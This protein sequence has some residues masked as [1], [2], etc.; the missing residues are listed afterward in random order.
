[1]AGASLPRG[2]ACE[3][4]HEF[5][6]FDEVCSRGTCCTDTQ[7]QIQTYAKPL[8]SKACYLC[9]AMQ[10]VVKSQADML[11]GLFQIQIL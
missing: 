10:R 4:V 2:L 7:I 6:D 5:F 3:D 1:M 9:F 11:G 8:P